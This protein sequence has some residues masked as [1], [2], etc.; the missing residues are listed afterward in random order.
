MSLPYARSIAEEHL[1]LQLHPCGC[2][3]GESVPVTHGTGQAEQGVFSQHVE[4]CTG[5]GTER[6]FVFR[7]PG[8]APR[9]DDRYGGA[10]PSQII[11]AGQWQWLAW[12]HIVRA[13]NVDDGSAD[14]R[15][16]FLAAVDYLKEL[17]KFIPPGEDA[18]PDSAFFTE[19][20]RRIRAAAVGNPFHRLWIKMWFQII[21]EKL[22]TL[23]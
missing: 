22:A 14:K 5:C 15:A 12:L 2:G 7:L 3:A 8:L 19:H 11:D 13:T 1:Y 18:V 21:D 17:R 23:P 4:R 6:E 10:D 16:F 20:G 9:Y